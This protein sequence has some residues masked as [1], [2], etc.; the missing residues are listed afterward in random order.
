MQTR[1]L[2]QALA[3][4]FLIDE[5]NLASI[6]SRGSSVLGREWPWLR[7]TTKRYLRTFPL[8]TRPRHR[9]VVAFLL[10]DRSFRFACR[11][12]NDQLQVHNRLLEPPVM[13]QREPFAA[14]AL[15]D[16][17]TVS[18]L[19]AWLRLDIGELL[20][21]ADPKGFSTRS[22]Q[23]ALRHYHHIM[24]T[25]P[26][27]DIRLLE[28]PKVRLKHLQRQILTGI[29]DR[30]PAHPAA[31]GFRKQHS[32]RSFVA[33]HVAQATVLR[34]DLRAFF[35]SIPRSRVQALFRTFGYPEA[36]ADLLGALCTT[37]TPMHVWRNCGADAAAGKLQAARTLYQRSH[38]PQGAP[39]SPA[40]ANLCCWRLDQRLASLA[41]A[42][43]VQY[44]RYADDLAFS[45]D[46]HFA[47]RAAR[48]GIHVTAIAAEEG[49]SVHH[50]KTRLMRR[51]VRQHL[52]GLV[53][54]QRANIPRRDYDALKAILYN[55]IRS[56]PEAQNRERLP[57]FRAHL[58]G[59][60]GYV[61]AIHPA[62]G[63]RLRSL[64]DR[65]SWA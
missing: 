37:A 10:A 1:V 39:T 52:A 60:I 49:L 44:T 8:H 41:V 53:I 21:F 51:G 11:T 61:A 12:F 36:V 62:H 19:A 65:I 38:L 55:C 16:I 24:V 63:A 30:I 32:I 7:A 64:F 54:N 58:E 17:A 6:L 46:A 27:G 25:K 35:P 13:Q 59:R 47:G 5:P 20:W 42:A 22:R 40:I 23:P 43:G 31:H 45:G 48:F 14:A 50:R 33:P 26:F 34:I 4:A 56:G 15:P 29:L 2:A 3:H 57:H 18:A 9:Q 28:A